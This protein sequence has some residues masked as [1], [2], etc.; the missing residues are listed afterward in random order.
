[1][2]IVTLAPG[3]GASPYLK[4]VSAAPTGSGPACVAPI[5]YTF[6]AVRGTAPTTIALPFGTWTLTTGATASDI[7]NP[8]TAAEIAVTAPAAPT[9]SVVDPLAGTVTLDP[10]VVTP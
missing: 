2:G 4:A 5:T 9:L 7:S 3:D 8:V 1:M 6:G 10:R